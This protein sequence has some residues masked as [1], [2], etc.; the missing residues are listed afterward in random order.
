MAY[1]GKALNSISTANIAVDTMTGDGS[2]NTMSISL[3]S[4]LTDSVNNVS[5]FISGVFQRPG[6]DYTL[7]G[8]TITFATAPSDGYSVV[9]VS[10]GD[11]WKDVIA[12]ATVYGASIADN[13]L[14]SAKII[15]LD[16][17]KLTGALPAV[18]GS[19]VTNLPAT[20]TVSSNDPATDTNPSE[21]VGAL[22]INSTSGETFLCTDATTDENVWYNVGGGEGNIGWN[23]WGTI[24]GY[25]VGGVPP[26]SNVIDKHSFT[27]DANATDVGDLVAISYSSC[28][29]QDLTHGY[30][31]GGITGNPQTGINTIQRFNFASAGSASSV[32]TLTIARGIGAGASS[33]THGYIAG[34][35]DNSTIATNTGINIIEKYAFSASTSG[36]DVG[37]LTG[38]RTSGS[39]CMSKTHGYIRGGRIASTSNN[40]IERWSF[41]SGTQD[42]TDVGDTVTLGNNFGF[43]GQNSE[44]HGYMTG[45]EGTGNS[46][47]LQKHA[48]AS[49][50][51]ASD[52]GTLA[53]ATTA[54]AGSSS[55][56]N[57]YI[58]G[59]ASTIN[60][61]QKFSFSSDGN[62][63]DIADLTVGRGNPGGL[64]N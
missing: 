36:S 26:E 25:T 32:G 1:L 23:G 47:R 12:D 55:N 30:V 59:G 24:S 5:V 13:T 2:T 28:G 19:A 52:I 58:S 11:S 38:N 9:A 51:D 37:D 17:S 50:A 49:S 15:G 63:S 21:G 62:A 53:V 8:S 64:S 14:T 6:T 29:S 4:K 41:A 10:K 42:A 31:V 20:H 3:G 22:W 27:T 39:G 57:G 46:T 16:A 40:I 33:K 60:N 7:S 45:G 35:D 34:G 44:T 48:F 43:N 54:G 56:T 61:I 18:D